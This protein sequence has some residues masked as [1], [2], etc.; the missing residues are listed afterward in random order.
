MFKQG[1]L[2]KSKLRTKEK[3]LFLM[4]IYDK[5]YSET[6]FNAIIIKDLSFKEDFC[7]CDEP[8]DV[9]Y[10]QYDKR[11]GFKSNVWNTCNFEKVT[12]SDIK[13]FL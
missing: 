12:W 13:H 5:N 1:D 4:V 7:E 11:A 8:C 2:V 6:Q 3:P 9:C 10:C